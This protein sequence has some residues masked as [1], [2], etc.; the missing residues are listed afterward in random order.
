MAVLVEKWFRW[1]LVVSLLLWLALWYFKDRLPDTSFYDSALL[2]EPLQTRTLETDFPVNAGG[3]AYRISPRFD[4]EL[5]GVIVSAH[6]TQGFFDIVHH[7]FWRDFINL[8]DLCV[9]WGDNVKSGVY[10]DLEFK[11]GTFTC[12]VSWSSREVRER[13]DPTQLSN[14]HLLIDDEAVKKTL[15]RAAPGERR[16][17]RHQYSPRRH[18]QRCLRNHLR[19]K[20]RNRQTGQS[21]NSAGLL[22]CRL[23]DG[24]RAGRCNRHVCSGAA[25]RALRLTR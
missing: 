10:R 22:D 2:S 5:D 20:L 18:R 9:I 6:D 23:D 3:E 7:K 15:M 4:Y 8:R 12:W 17:S 25:P 24:S 16:T 11:N 13:F 1:L 19:R 21:E 14:N